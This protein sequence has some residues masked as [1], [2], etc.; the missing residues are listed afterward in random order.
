MVKVLSVLLG[1]VIGSSVCGQDGWFTV[2]TAAGTVDD[3]TR[4]AAFSDAFR[5]CRVRVGNVCGSGSFVGRDAA[6]TFVMTNA[7]V[8]GT[9]LGR[10]VSV[11]Y[12]DRTKGSAVTVRGVII[13]AAYSDRTLSDW[14]LLRCPADAFGSEQPIRMSRGAPAAGVRHFT[15]GCPRCVV[16]RGQV[17]T[18]RV[19]G[20]PWRWQPDAVGGQSGSAVTRGG[21]QY[22]V[23]TWSWGGDGAG[24]QTRDIWESLRTR[25]VSTVDRPDGLEEM[26]DERSDTEVGFFAEASIADLPIWHDDAAPIEGDEAGELLDRLRADSGLTPEQWVELL[27]LLL[28][29]LHLLRRG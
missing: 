18:S 22:G 8:S 12:F 23:L 24:Q 16:P 19:I 7:H 29:V 9:Q 13:A 28:Q 5:A 10:V 6:A 20:R 14:A 2:L 4:E 3:A 1:L 26:S 21:V 17:L 27:R 11:E 15:W 25:S